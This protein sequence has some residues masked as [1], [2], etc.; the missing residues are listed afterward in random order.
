MQYKIECKECSEI[1][2]HVEGSK[3]YRNFTHH[4]KNKHNTTASKY[5]KKYDHPEFLDLIEINK[6]SKRADSPEKVAKLNDKARNS[7]SQDEY[8]NLCECQVCGLKAKQLYKHVFNIHSITVDNY[9]LQFPG[10]RLESDEYLQYLSESRTGDNNPMHGNGSSEMSPFAIEFYIAKGHSEDEATKLRDEFKQKVIDNK[11]KS[12]YSTTPE[13]Y[14][15]KYDIGIIEA[16]DMQR[17]RQSTNSVEN[18]AER[19]GISIDDAKKI[20]DEITNKWMNNLQSKSKEELEDIQRRKLGKSYSKSATT[21]FEF[22]CN[23]LNISDAIY[24]KNEYIL[25]YLNSDNKK[26]HYAFDFKF[27]NNVIEYYGDIYH[28]NPNRFEANDYPKKWISKR[29]KRDKM[30]SEIWEYDRIRETTIREH[31]YNLLVI[32]ES[33][34][35]EN[36]YRVLERCRQFLLGRK[37]GNTK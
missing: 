4:L 6:K 20:R 9:K 36:K 35:K 18:I 7:M 32:W 28:A 17:K 34:V 15:K 31:G 30:A 27:G 23:E 16:R 33:E 24:G 25:T 21:F 12:S 29:S 26:R 11:D 8:D 1:I 22:V 14:M 5:K 19:Q 3:L 13:Y 37:D 10:H 2:E